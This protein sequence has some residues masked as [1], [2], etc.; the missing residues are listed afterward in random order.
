MPHDGWLS[1][2]LQKGF[3][4]LSWLTLLVEGCC[5]GCSCSGWAGMFQWGFAAIRPRSDRLFQG[6]GDGDGAGEVRWHPCL[7]GCCRLQLN[8]SSQFRAGSA[9]E[10]LPPRGS[11]VSASGHSSRGSTVLRASPGVYLC[12]NLDVNVG[13]VRRKRKDSSNSSSSRTGCWR[14]K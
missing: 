10:G 9:R 12:L 1:V 5:R 3:F 4:P 11:F 14:S 2:C 6:D 8:S 7:A 13:A